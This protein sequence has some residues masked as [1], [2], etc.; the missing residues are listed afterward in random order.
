MQD[1]TLRPEQRERRTRWRDNL[2]IAPAADLNASLGNRRTPLSAV[3][4]EDTFVRSVGVTALQDHDPR[5][6]PAGQDADTGTAVD[7]IEPAH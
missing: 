7:T 6:A 1:Q 4:D 3:L 2:T 5:G